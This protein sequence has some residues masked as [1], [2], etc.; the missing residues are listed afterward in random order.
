MVLR[1]YAYGK[2]QIGYIRFGVELGM[3]KLIKED[4]EIYKSVLVISKKIFGVGNIM[5]VIVGRVYRH[6]K[7]NFYVVENVAT[8][9]ETGEKMVVY[10]ALY[11][12]GVVYVRPYDMFAEKVNLG[13]QEY[14]FQL[15]EIKSNV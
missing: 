12:N 15:Q 4:V 3:L 14:R 8:H 1:L 10:R 6:Y 9:S 13:G 2:P 11:E 5:D 7:G